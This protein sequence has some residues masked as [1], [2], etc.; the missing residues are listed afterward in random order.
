MGHQYVVNSVLWNWLDGFAKRVLSS[1]KIMF[2]AQSKS[3]FAGK[4][5]VNSVLSS[6]ARFSNKNGIFWSE[7]YRQKWALKCNLPLAEILSHIRF[8]SGFVLASWICHFRSALGWHILVNVYRVSM[9][10]SSPI[11]VL[12]FLALIHLGQKNVE[13]GTRPLS[14]IKLCRLSDNPV[15]HWSCSNQKF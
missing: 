8:V 15:R 9:Q 2:L 3:E 4:L 14:K 12:T 7:Q 5:P 10:L 1:V 11:C 13:K 6:K